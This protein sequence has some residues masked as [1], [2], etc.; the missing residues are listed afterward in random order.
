MSRTKNTIRNI[1]TGFINK[2]VVLIFPF[3][4]KTII[5]QKLGS[6]YLGL[7][8]LFTSILQVLNLTELGFSS[9]IIFSM[10]KPIA[11]HDTKTICAL[12]NFYKKIYRTIGLIIL[13]I[14]LLILPFLSKLIQ[15]TYP[16][17]I[18]IYLLYLIYLFNTVIS[19][20]MFA[21]KSSLLV[22]HQRNDIVNNIN[23]IVFIIQYIIQI[24]IL[25]ILKNYYAFIIVQT[26]T[27]I[28]NN[29]L[30]AYISKKKYPKYIC[31][32]SIDKDSKNSIKKRVSGLMIQKICETTRNSLDSIYISS[33]LGLNIVAIYNNYYSIMCAVTGMLGIIT[34]SMISSTG[35]SIVTENIQKNYENM[36]KFNFIYMWLSGICTVCLL[37]LYQ[38]FME[39]WMG[40]KYMFSLNV[41]ICFCVYFYT[42]KMGDIRAVFHDANGLWYEAKYRAIIETVLNIVLNYILGIK[43]GVIGII[44]ATEISLFFVNFLYGSSIVFRYYF[45]NNKLKEFY[46]DHLKYILTTIIIAIITYKI[47]SF[48]KIS[49]FLELLVKGIICLL[50]SNIIYIVVYYRTKIFNDSL[51]FIKKVIPK[52][53]K[54]K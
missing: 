9:A 31:Q 40:T 3:F 27:T 2:F 54:L 53:H 49:G 14:G 19:Y 17:N 30:I 41:V 18:D 51:L 24:F 39:I 35:N 26:F 45:K 36:R 5:I 44:M 37:C 21:Y 38:P 28:I 33:L 4:I 10:Y 34:T 8:G 48:I 50:L 1:M 13:I 11:K 7:N 22:A 20:L 46:F 42:L 29:I 12:L 32:G 15:G 43:F 16:A 23:T 47:C 25:L 52:K 6:E